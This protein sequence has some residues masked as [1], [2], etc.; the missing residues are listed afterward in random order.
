[1]RQKY[2]VLARALNTGRIIERWLEY[3]EFKALQRKSELE[4]SHSDDENVEVEMRPVF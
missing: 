1:M 3:C 4:D 2:V